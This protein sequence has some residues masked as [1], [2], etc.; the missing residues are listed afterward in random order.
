[1]NYKTILVTAVAMAASA[2]LVG[3]ATSSG[4]VSLGPDTFL[5]NT[6]ADVF[7]GGASSARG[8][9]F[10]EAQKHC[11]MLGKEFLTTDLKQGGFVGGGG[12][13][14]VVFRCL[15]KDDPELQ[16]PTLERTPD[17]IIQDN[18]KP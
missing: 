10:R 6:A 13:T 4:V 9:A 1:M 11:Q 7:R 2:F 5:I 16:R 3:C 12:L 14:E 8:S 17:T 18:R 15:K